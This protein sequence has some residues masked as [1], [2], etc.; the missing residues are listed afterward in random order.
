MT[1]DPVNSLSFP[2]T[3]DPLTPTTLLKAVHLGCKVVVRDRR[4]SEK[5]IAK[6]NK[7]GRERD[8]RRER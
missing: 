1:D 5:T 6:D 8:E 7:E 4:A 2:M 3:E